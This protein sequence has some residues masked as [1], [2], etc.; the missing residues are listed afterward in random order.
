MIQ[1]HQNNKQIEAFN[2][3]LLS[4]PEQENFKK[5]L[6]KC[7]DMDQLATSLGLLKNNIM[8]C[9]DYTERVEFPNTPKEK[10][11]RTPKP[12]T[13]RN[14]KNLMNKAGWS[15]VN[16][17]VYLMA[18][19]DIVFPTTLIFNIMNNY[20]LSFPKVAPSKIIP[21]SFRSAMNNLYISTK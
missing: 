1:E 13:V 19:N 8:M 4:S 6:S 21:E 15:W 2:Q 17:N 20:N 11:I 5:M 12:H 9:F 7:K 18:C 16:E 10:T 14:W 3:F